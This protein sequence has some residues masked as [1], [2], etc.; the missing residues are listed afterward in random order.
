MMQ[1]E[2]F[3]FLHFGSTLSAHAP[4]EWVA[5]VYEFIFFTTPLKALLLSFA[6]EIFAGPF[7][8]WKRSDEEYVRTFLTKGVQLGRMQ[9]FPSLILH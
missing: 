6:E 4:L 1:E 9:T 5:V 7:V 2:D 8:G 3:S